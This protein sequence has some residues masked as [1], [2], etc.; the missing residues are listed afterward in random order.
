MIRNY[1]IFRDTVI[2]VINNSGL[3]IGAI[4]FILKDILHDVNENY[5]QAINKEIE[6]SRK[7]TETTTANQA[8]VGTP[9]ED[10]V[11]TLPP[12]SPMADTEEDEPI[13]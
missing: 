8:E 7:A 1:Q 13:E 9:V 2:D 5:T 4:K 6:D 3:D 11:D 10:N 12:S